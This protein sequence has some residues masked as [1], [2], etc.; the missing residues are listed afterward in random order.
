MAFSK[1][2]GENKNVKTDKTDD[3]HCVITKA[4][5]GFDQSELQRQNSS[6]NIN[7]EQLAKSTKKTTELASNTKQAKMNKDDKPVLLYA[8]PSM[9]LIKM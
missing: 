8:H 9:Y 2:R 6:V 3:G 7:T 5:P 1:F 4:H